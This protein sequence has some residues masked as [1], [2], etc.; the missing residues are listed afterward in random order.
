MA[1][2]KLLTVVPPYRGM[3]SVSAPGKCPDGTAPLVRNYLT[4]LPGKLSMRGGLTQE[5]FPPAQLSTTAKVVS[6]IWVWNDKLL[7][8]FH[9][10]KQ[11]ETQH[12][13]PPWVAPYWKA[14][15]AKFL[16]EGDTTMVYVDL[17]TGEHS[18]IGVEGKYQPSGQSSR[19]EKYSYGFS[20]FDASTSSVAGGFQSRRKLMKW[21]GTA[22]KPVPLVNAPEGGQAVRSY[23]NRL[24]VLGGTNFPHNGFVTI[25]K[26]TSLSKA[27]PTANIFGMTESQAFDEFHVGDSIKEGTYFAAGTTITGVFY[28]EGLVELVFNKNPIE[29]ATKLVGILAVKWVSGPPIESNTLFFSDQGGP[30]EDKLGQWQD[31][32]SGL[33]NQIVVG[34]EDASDFGVQLAVVGQSLIIFK[35]HSIW[36]LYG[37]SPATF[38]IKNLTTER[39]CIDQASVCEVDGGVFFASQNGI[40][41]YDGS[42]FTAVDSAISNVTRA[43]F[44]LHSGDKGE[45][46]PKEDFGRTSITYIGNNYI[47]VTVQGQNQ[48]STTSSAGAIT[49]NGWCGYMHIPT[50]AWAEFTSNNLTA[51][52]VPMTLGTTKA[53]PWIWD[54]GAIHSALLLTS[55]PQITGS[56]TKYSDSG[57]TPSKQIP[58]RFNSD[59]INL[60]SPGYISQM[61][62]FLFDYKFISG[63]S[64]PNSNGWFVKL[65]R[66]DETT[67]LLPVIQVPAQATNSPYFGRQFRGDNFGEVLNCELIVEWKE[68]ASFIPELAEV[69]DTTFEIQTTRQRASV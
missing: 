25:S 52:N 32:V 41:F 69:Y 15:E 6:G 18:E 37:Y 57:I 29:N 65:I 13:L 16:A 46:N 14:A 38:Q 58:A 27:V 68:G 1:D 4:H 26:E 43:A 48:K 44:K 22:T 54:G 51:C 66:C 30:T 61:H 67:E 50:G 7:I 56:E 42:S 28:T 8:G 2:L 45:H 35:R 40:E 55:D 3:N 5:P 9:K 12:F 20:Y 23:L 59:R 31:D 17:A 10:L 24:F 21:D 53:I 19:L 33:L 47:M 49:G 36:S 11:G 60:S 34:D 62:R 39:G 64:H 63:A